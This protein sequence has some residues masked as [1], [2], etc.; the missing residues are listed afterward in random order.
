[1]PA[2]RRAETAVVLFQKVRET[3]TWL[4][5]AGYHHVITLVA[6]DLGDTLLGGLGGGFE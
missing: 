3:I 2:V 6:R 4:V 1:M 5:F